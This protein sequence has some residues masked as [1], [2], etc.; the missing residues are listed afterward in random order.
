MK[1]LFI[2]ALF[3]FLIVSCS[4]ETSMDSNGGNSPEGT[5]SLFKVVTTYLPDNFD[6]YI[7]EYE[8]DANDL[9][10]QVKS[11]FKIKRTNGSIDIL[12]GTAHFYRDNLQRIIRIGAFPDTSSINTII[13]YADASS[14]KVIAAVILKNNGSSTELLDSTVFE[15]G[16]NGKISKSSHFI[17]AGNGIPQLS[18][19]QLYGYDLNGNVISKALYQ[20]DDANGS[21]EVALTYQWEYDE[22]LNPMFQNEIGYIQWGELWPEYSSKNNVTKQVNV[23]A[24]TPSDQ[25]QYSYQYDQ[26]SRPS[27]QLQIGDPSNKTTYYYK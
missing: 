18:T 15:Y 8:Y 22:K 20:D 23:Y 2:W 13:H 6:Y 5:K 21:F 25:L 17:P 14:D 16:N 12:Q 19:Y 27:L 24:A 4:K 26:L 10:L 1:K 9:I 11:I 7:R 3:A